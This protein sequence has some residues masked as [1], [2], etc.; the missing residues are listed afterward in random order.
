MAGFM[1]MMG[2]MGGGGGGMSGGG[3]GGGAASGMGGGGWIMPAIA[4][5]TNRMSKIEENQ[6]YLKRRERAANE[7]RWTPW[8]GIS[9]EAIG[10]KP[11]GPVATTSQN[12]AMF[13]G[14]NEANKDKNER[15]R[16]QQR[17]QVQQ[18]PQESSLP[19]QQQQSTNGWMGMMQQQPSWG[20]MYSNRGTMRG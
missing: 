18:Q 20:S 14:Q 2:G 17:Q 3:G 10:E 15:Q 4:A 19:P 9:P 11:E 1:D 6:R 8:T 16:M 13:M 12:V 7:A 5:T